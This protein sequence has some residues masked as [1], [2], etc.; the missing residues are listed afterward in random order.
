MEQQEQVLQCHGVQNIDITIDTSLD[1]PTLSNQ[2]IYQQIQDSFHHI[3]HP[4]QIENDLF[5]V[6]SMEDF[7]V[8]AC[9]H[10]ILLN[11][12]NYEMKEAFVVVDGNHSLRKLSHWHR[13]IPRVKPFFAVKCNPDPVL[14]KS[15]VLA[16]NCGF[17]CASVGEINL[18]TSLGARSKRIIFA[19]PNKPIESV[20]FALLKGV[21]TMTFDS[22]YELDKIKS[23]VDELQSENITVVPELVLRIRVP[24]TH[25]KNALGVK[26][27]AELSQ[28]HN[29]VDYAV[30]LNI[31][32]VGISFHAGSGCYDASAYTDAIDYARKAFDIA[33]KLGVHFSLLDIGGGYPGLATREENNN[34][35]VKALTLEDIAER[36]NPLIDRLF[37]PHIQ[38]I[39]EP[40]RYFVEGSTNLYLQLY[41]S[42]P[43]KLMKDISSQLED[44][45]SRKHNSEDV[46]N[47]TCW[48]VCE[49]VLGCF[50]D[51][52]LSEVL[53]QPRLVQSE[54][55]PTN[56][57]SLTRHI[58]IGS[59]G[60]TNSIIHPDLPFE[61][62]LNCWIRY[63][64]FGAYTVSLASTK[65][66]VAAAQRI[67]TW[68]FRD[69]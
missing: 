17:D 49:G 65:F 33:E 24:D 8:F 45:P 27:G 7:E 6:D 68:A 11:N 3:Q 48:F 54:A 57:S 5:Q 29:L 22:T 41:K 19:N 26:F 60:L 53:F 30:S 62:Y 18:V 34:S 43:I 21:C 52:V 25:S 51:A 28:V 15:L 47:A 20:K 12:A 40:G 61:P 42:R 44:V 58:L 46:Q 38:I 63:T 35:Q 36:I 4:Y 59:E 67:Y 64:Y 2:E 39:S 69:V 37:P 56:N 16:N 23:V 1:N 50:K 32:V 13:L 66:S 10:N 9:S 14:I 55:I 31:P